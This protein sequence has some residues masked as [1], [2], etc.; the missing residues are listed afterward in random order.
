MQASTGEQNPKQLKNVKTR[1]QSSSAGQSVSKNSEV[2]DDPATGPHHPDQELEV[3]CKWSSQS[4]YVPPKDGSKEIAKEMLS[5]SKL[6][7][8]RDELWK[9]ANRKFR[10]QF[11][12]VREIELRRASIR[13][14]KGRVFVTVT[15]EKDFGQIEDPIPDC[16]KTRLE[17]FQ[18][19]IGDD[20]GIKIYYLKPLCVE[21]GNELI[22]TTQEQLDSTMAELRAETM[23]EFRKL[24]PAH[25]AKQLV[26]VLPKLL[27]GAPR[28]LLSAFFGRKKQFI[29]SYQARLEFERRKRAWEAKQFRKSYR[30][31]PCEYT[32]I[33]D[34]TDPPRTEDVLAHYAE[35]K[36]LSLMTHQIY[37]IAIAASL[38]WFLTA[39]ALANAVA[40][41]TVTTVAVV[42]PVFV[43]EFPG[44]R[45]QLLKIGHFDEIDGVMHVEV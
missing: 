11:T 3:F 22:F 29:E 10:D 12:H 7:T 44:S 16:V 20:S 38:P 21:V 42:D 37:L 25:V 13:L 15:D 41:G 30:T 9:N 31:D 1:S 27:L 45:G 43:A 17:E 28:K 14:P 19:R 26:T 35:E 23:A 32:E 39:V 34:L 8:K 6:L 5:K 40:V 18:S 33:L 24:L 36:K 2:T 4:I